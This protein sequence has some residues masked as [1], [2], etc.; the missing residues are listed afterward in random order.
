M[1]CVT[2]LEKRTKRWKTLVATR[3]EAE[4]YSLYFKYQGDVPK[5]E[6]ETPTGAYGEKDPFLKVKYFYDQTSK[7]SL[8]TSTVLGRI[9]KSSHPLNKVAEHLLPYVNRIND[10]PIRIVNEIQLEGSDLKLGIAG[11][12]SPK[13]NNILINNF[14]TFKGKGGEPTIIHEV[15]HSLTYGAL[16]GNNENV[17]K[18]NEIYEYLKPMFP[19]YNPET[20]EG[21]YALRNLDEFIVALF[22][23]SAFIKELIK[24]PAIDKS[25]TSVLKEI[26]DYILSLFNISEEDSIYRQAFNVASNILEDAALY[27]DFQKEQYEATYFMSPQ[28]NP[29]FAAQLRQWYETKGSYFSN[30]EQQANDT[31]QRLLK[32]Y[33]NAVVRKPYPTRT[34]KWVVTVKKPVDAAVEEDI[35]RVTNEGYN[36]DYIPMLTKVGDNQWMTPEGDIISDADA[37]TFEDV[38]A[39]ESFPKFKVIKPGVEELFESN[40]ELAD[41]VY[42]ALGFNNLR[43]E[44]SNVIIDQVWKRLA[45]EGI[46]NAD[47]LI[48]TRET[49]NNKDFNKFW[50]AVKDVD[51]QN[52]INFFE[53]EKQKALDSY[54]KYKGEFDP[55]TG[56]F[57]SNDTSFFDKKIKD[58]NTLL[59]QK[60]QAQQLYSQYLDTIFP[61]SKVKDIVYHGGWIT[62]E[63]IFRIGDG[64][65]GKGIYF[66]PKE[67]ADN[68]RNIMG[69]APNLISV[70]LNIQNPV[71]FDDSKGKKSKSKEFINSKLNEFPNNDGIIYESKLLIDNN[72]GV[73]ENF[74]DEYKVNRPEQ[75]HILGSKQDIEGF[76]DFVSTPE[77]LP[78]FKPK[79]A[80]A[81]NSLE[82]E[83]FRSAL[84]TSLQVGGTINFNYWSEGTSGEISNKDIEVLSVEDNTFV[85]RYPDG[86]ERVF[87]FDNVV[88]K[89]VPG[90]YEG[91]EQVYFKSNLA[92][93]K[94]VNVTSNGL[95][96]SGTVAE[97]G[98]DN[99]TILDPDGT[100]YTLKYADLDK[101]NYERRIFQRASEMKS[102]LEEQIQRFSKNAKSKFQLDRIALLQQAVAQLDT[103]SGS[104][105]LIKFMKLLQESVFKSKALMKTLS[106]SEKDL[107]SMSES[108]KI[109]EVNRRLSKLSFLKDYVDSMMAFKKMAFEIA[110]SDSS[111]EL[112]D[113]AGGLALEIDSADNMYYEVAIP[114]IADWLWM[115]FPKKLNSQLLLIGEK[116]WTKERLIQE[117]RQPTKDLDFLNSYGVP[118]ANANDVITGLFSKA[119]KKVLQYAKENHINLEKNLLPF[120]KKV[121]ATGAKMEEV[122]KKFYTIKQ[123]ETEEEVIVDGQPTIQ[124]VTKNVRVFIEKYDLQSYYDTVRNFTSQIR[125]LNDKIAVTDNTSERNA[126]FAE[127]KKILAAL[128]AYQKKTAINYSAT[129]MNEMMEK[130]NK[131]NPSKFLDNLKFYTAGEETANSFKYTTEDGAVVYY[132]YKGN[133]YKPNKEA[134][135]PD[136]GRKIFL[137]QDYENLMKEP[138]E[139]V[140]LYN[141]VKRIYDEKNNML[142]EHLKMKGVVP[143]FYEQS[144]LKDLS[145]TISNRGKYNDAQELRKKDK[146]TFT[147]LNGEPYQNVPLG[148]TKILDVSE[149]SDNI[150]QSF[151]LWANDVQMF[152]AKNDV[153]G[154]VENL[155]TVLEKNRPL[156]EK[157]EGKSKI[158]RR[159]EVI[160]KYANQVLYGETRASNEWWDRVFDYM[161]KFTALTRML[162]KPSSALNNLII[163]N[164]ALLSEAVGGR[165]FTTKELWRAHKKY[166]DLV[167]NNKEK[168]NNMLITLDAI[169]GRF[170]DEIGTDFQTL[171]D[172]FGFNTAFSLNNLAEHQIQAVSMLALLEKWGVEVP[173]N[174]MFEVDKLPDNFLGTLHELNK[175][176]NGVYSESDRLY[177]QDEALFRL[178]LQFRKYI[179]P[180]FRTKWSGMTQKGNDKYRMDLE[181][182]TI[183][184][185]YYR[186]FGE[187]VWNNVVKIKNLPNLIAN[188]NSLNE[189]EKEG[190]WRGLVDGVAF[191]SIGLL[192]LPLAG[193]DDDDWDDGEHSRFE[194]LIHWELIYQL[195]RLRA[196]I[197]TYIPGFG[198]S[199][200]SRLVNQPFAAASTATQLAKI[201]GI[202][203]DFEEDDEG[204]ISIWKQYERDYGRFKKGD[205]K[206]LQP[207]S[208]LNPLDNPYEDL[209]PH[210]QYN[211]FKG[212]S[213]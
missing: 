20:G 64:E 23:D 2:P 176:N 33:T 208:K 111:Q 17:Q 124:K 67:A 162:I 121:Q 184:L 49:I 140:D 45:N 167:A 43:K 117:L 114:N 108:E 37:E 205:L 107:D 91:H 201:V 90:K 53:S 62:K 9:A 56:T 29:N 3:G 99:F 63:D 199:D 204:N 171:Q 202:V 180:T 132:N 147:K 75:I 10:S 168:L 128:T 65:F 177:H 98:G 77:S 113:K 57:T 84:E 13:N 78:K 51:I 160:K 172:T 55:T 96:Y 103:Y 197:G 203:F 196:D 80:N 16:R 94:T 198:F 27:S 60:Q 206:I 145:K 193:A 210:V 155:T 104:V 182:G 136:T 105:D 52:V 83:Q 66:A 46:T 72:L 54:S 159:L 188:Y 125:A 59:Q 211:D 152:K 207:I 1:I 181:A 118:V 137:T 48:G 174:G 195:A 44:Y 47:S 73:P 149:S 173:E 7:E 95:E 76:R 158:N 133:F 179:V 34:G 151:L 14:A 38:Q 69:D 209:F 61:D 186:A 71:F 74:N 6:Y 142:P 148:Y 120:F 134:I 166:V 183:E 58:L 41:A 70:I 79:P 138:Q 12:Y 156:G 143:V 190:V 92:V 115:C 88:S 87:R 86:E 32:F 161:G 22:S 40:P 5:S 200:Q 189:V 31:Y 97:I 100:I 81:L 11:V 93:G 35:K 178:F 119:V 185:G 141:E 187:F 163:G 30:T 82:V 169:Q 165:N 146:K 15:I 212:A 154:S 106:E 131:S 135:D 21:T 153:I 101:E 24:I 194:N 39:P 144:M 50:S 112:K 109:E 127:K 164:Y 85:G 157:G 130:L 26:F 36:K 102:L 8:K 126:L 42:E 19:E 175:A 68:Y 28:A 122:Y 18:F 191:A 25:K 123:M 89:A 213:R 110:E 192:F 170:K 4:A 139:V 150:M 129:Q 116:E